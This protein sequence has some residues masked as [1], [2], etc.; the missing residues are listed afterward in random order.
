MLKKEQNNSSP[1][2]RSDDLL[3]NRWKKQKRWPRQFHPRRKIKGKRQEEILCRIRR[4]DH[5]EGVSV[6]KQCK[7]KRRN[8][9]W[10]VGKKPILR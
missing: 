2:E 5:A 3:R 8:S 10:G 9:V 4:E 7:K 6:G 1:R